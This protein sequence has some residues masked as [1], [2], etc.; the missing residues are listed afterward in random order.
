MPPKKGHPINIKLKRED[1]PS[2][3]S[4]QSINLA[5][6]DDARREIK[7][8]RGNVTVYILHD[9]SYHQMKRYILKLPPDREEA[10]RSIMENFPEKTDIY[11]QCA[12]YFRG[13]SRSQ[14]FLDANH[15]TGYFSLVNL[16][17]RKGL[18]LDA[19]AYDVTAMTEFIKGQGWLLQGEMTVNLKGKDDEFLYLVDWFKER[20]QFR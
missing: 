13:F 16:L 19:S 1:L 4:I 15:R 9:M 6:L 20:L 3:R 12:Y 5:F 14:I 10:L 17:R 8:G 18:C 2:I 11:E 7:D